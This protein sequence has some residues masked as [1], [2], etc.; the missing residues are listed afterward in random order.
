MFWDGAMPSTTHS[1]THNMRE[2]LIIC[3][4]GWVSKM[5]TKMKAKVCGSEG[6]KVDKEIPVPLI[7]QILMCADKKMKQRSVA[8]LNTWKKRVGGS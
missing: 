4:L 7:K 5:Q 2:G 6:K 1:G 8:W 3:S